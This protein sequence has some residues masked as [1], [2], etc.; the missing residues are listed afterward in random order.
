M[1]ALPNPQFWLRL[2]FRKLL[3]Q[4]LSGSVTSRL[5]NYFTT[6]DFSFNPLY[7]FGNAPRIMPDLYGPGTDDWGISL[8]KNTQFKE[9][10]R[11]HFRAEAFNA[12]NRVQFGN[13]GTN[14]TAGTFGQISTQAN[15][16]RDIQLALKLMF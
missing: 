16:A 2:P 7:T 15:L 14:I 3:L 4:P 13:P 12:F 1:I 11:L 10:Y 6:S 9:R 8:F 5:N